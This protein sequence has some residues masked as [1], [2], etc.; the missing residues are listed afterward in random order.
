MGIVAFSEC[1]ISEIANVATVFG[2]FD[3]SDFWEKSVH[4]AKEYVGRQLDDLTV[5]AVEHE[6][7][8]KL[9]STYVEFMKFQNGGFPRRPNHRTKEPTS[10]AQDHIAVHGFFSVGRDTDNSLCGYFKSQ[11]WV[12]EWGYPPIVSRGV[13]G[14][15]LNRLYPLSAGEV[16][17]R[18]GEL[19]ALE[20]LAPVELTCVDRFWR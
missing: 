18:V 4:A 15:L 20:R 7:G 8:Y 10:W 17:A 11:F 2:D 5:R 9:P 12:D 13:V 6:L 14:P 19:F 1:A 3:M 16:L